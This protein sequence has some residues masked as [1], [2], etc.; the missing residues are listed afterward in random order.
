MRRT[1]EFFHEDF[2]NLGLNVRRSFVH[3]KM[4]DG[5]GIAKNDSSPAK[6]H[7]DLKDAACTTWSAPRISQE[8]IDAL[9]ILI[10]P[11]LVDGSYIIGLHNVAAVPEQPVQLG[12]TSEW[13]G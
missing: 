9:T 6:E 1:N 12:R 2:G 10:H 11:V 4:C 5:L 8:K 13:C 7:V 3:V